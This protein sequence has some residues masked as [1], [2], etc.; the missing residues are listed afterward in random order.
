MHLEDLIEGEPQIDCYLGTS[1]DL[2]SATEH[3]FHIPMLILI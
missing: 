3:L 2:A 1:F